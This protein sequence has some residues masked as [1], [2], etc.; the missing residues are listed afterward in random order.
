MFHG[1]SGKRTATRKVHA[2]LTFS[3]I[4]GL[5]LLPAVAGLGGAP[6]VEAATITAMT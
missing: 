3:T 6:P 5:V 4:V 2:L 1:S